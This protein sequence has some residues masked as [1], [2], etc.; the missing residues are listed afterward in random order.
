MAIAEVFLW[1]VAAAMSYI[2]AALVKWA[3]GAR[4]RLTGSVVLFLLVMMF[5]MF[6]GAF[7]YFAY[8]G[9]TGL[10]LGLWIAAGLMAVSVF[11]VFWLFVQEVQQRL[12]QGDAFQPPQMVSLRTFALWVTLAVFTGEFVMGRAFQLASGEAVTVGVGVLGALGAGASSLASDWFLFPMAAEMGLTVLFLRARIPR[13][14]QVALALQ[15]ASMFASPTALAAPGWVVGSSVGAAVLMVGLF[16]YVMALLYRGDRLPRPVLSY[17]ARLVLV[18]VAMAAG[19]VV[20]ALTGSP[21]LFALS[22]IAQMAVFFTTV[23]VPE[24]LAPEPAP[25]SGAEGPRAAGA[26]TSSA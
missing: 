23:V 2:I 12:A 24:A 6:L 3:A 5:A 4:T 26:P 9:S 7:L 25:R 8:P 22:A 20:W 13:P 21:A 17:L 18:Y 11:P 19:L 1:P 14:L 15:A 10:L 16:G